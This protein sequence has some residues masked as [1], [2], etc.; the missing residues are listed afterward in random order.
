ME[1]YRD[2]SNQ[3]FT[4]CCSSYGSDSAFLGSIQPQMHV[5]ATFLSQGIQRI[6]LIGG[7][8]SPRNY[9]DGLRYIC[10]DTRA[11]AGATAHENCQQSNDK[12]ENLHIEIN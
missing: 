6:C 10:A 8:P 4:A 11:M 2:E 3:I 5:E 9:M 7:N 12:A 1:D